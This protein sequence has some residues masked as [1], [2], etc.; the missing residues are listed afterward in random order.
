MNDLNQIDGQIRQSHKMISDEL[1]H[2]QNVHAKQTIKTLKK[3]ARTILQ[4]ERHKMYVLKQTLS[5]LDKPLP[6]LPI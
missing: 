4:A 2:Y 5:H 3:Y 6:T 1:A